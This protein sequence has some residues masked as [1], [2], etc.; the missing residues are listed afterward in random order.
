LGKYQGQSEKHMSLEL[1]K[2][3]GNAE[4]TL[5]FRDEKTRFACGVC[6]PE[7]FYK[8]EPRH[9]KGHCESPTHRFAMENPGYSMERRFWESLGNPSGSFLYCDSN[10][11][12]L[13]VLCQGK[14]LNTLHAVYAHHLSKLHTQ[15]LENTKKQDV[16]LSAALAFIETE[17]GRQKAE[18][19]KDTTKDL[20]E[21]WESM[22]NSLESLQWNEGRTHYRCLLCNNGRLN[23]AKWYGIKSH[24]W[25]ERHMRRMQT[26]KRP[27]DQ[28][29]E[30]Q[31]DE[32][33]TKKRTTPLVKEEEEEVLIVVPL[34]EEEE[35]SSHPPETLP[36]PPPSEEEAAEGQRVVALPPRK[37][38]PEVAPAPLTA[39]W[40]GAVLPAEEYQQMTRERFKE[41]LNTPEVTQA[42]VNIALG[43]LN[44]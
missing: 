5:R 36:P 42:M 24:C 8:T 43:V 31:R 11:R 27:R 23:K 25:S 20:E 41:V 19:Q 15:A 4:Y 17:G 39:R 1:W 33:E 12:F 26:P 7:F 40:A 6:S 35:E 3:L 16:A 32:N 9:M 38:V 30:E 13:C 22:G 21:L 2:E 29:E 18:R 37:S 44:K 34:D 10:T 14:G 28:E